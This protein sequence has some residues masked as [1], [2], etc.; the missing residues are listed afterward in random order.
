MVM[1]VAPG[2]PEHKLELGAGG[3]G[4]LRGLLPME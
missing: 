2:S 3:S 4:R 1:L